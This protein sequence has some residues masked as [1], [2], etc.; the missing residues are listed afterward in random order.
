MLQFQRRAARPGGVTAM[1]SV[2]LFADTY[3]LDNY[4]KYSNRVFVA[5]AVG[6]NAI[7]QLDGSRMPKDFWVAV[8]FEFIYFYLAH[9]EACARTVGGDDHADRV[10]KR[11]GESLINAAVDYVFDDVY[12]DGNQTLKLKHMD[13]LAD[14]MDIYGKYEHAVPEKEGEGSKGTALW[15][16]C[17]KVAAFV[18]H[19]DD[20][21][22][23][24]TCHAHIFDSL[25]VLDTDTFLVFAH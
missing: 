13:E 4:Q 8:V 11:L 20:T 21:A 17:R 3:T 25:E 16:F 1:E 19:P 6:A 18:G 2:S 9:A 23:M 10:F 24:M 12:E 15:T 22:Y 7:Q 14:R 5:S